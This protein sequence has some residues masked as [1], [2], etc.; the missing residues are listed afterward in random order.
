MGRMMETLDNMDLGAFIEQKMKHGSH[1]NG[2]CLTYGFGD[3]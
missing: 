3:G 2:S 1:K